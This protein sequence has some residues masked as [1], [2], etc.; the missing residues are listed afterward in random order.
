MA[1][2][3][4]PKVPLKKSG[5]YFFPL[6]AADQV[7]TDPEAG[8]KLDAALAEMAAAI[9]AAGEAAQAAATAA[10]AASEAAQAAVDAVAAATALAEAAM[11]KNC[12]AFDA[13]TGTLAITL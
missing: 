1:D 5:K 9:T 4:K 12:F 13:A 3:H 7:Y 10:A 11:P 2:V 8:K 6:T